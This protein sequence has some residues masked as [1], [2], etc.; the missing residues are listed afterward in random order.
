MPCKGKLSWEQREC[1]TN[2]NIKLLINSPLPPP[3]PPP[4]QIP[5][6]TTPFGLKSGRFNSHESICTVTSWKQSQNVR[7]E[8]I[9]PGPSSLHP[10]YPHP[11]LSR[12]ST[13]VQLPLP[14]AHRSP[15]PDGAFPRRADTP[16]SSLFLC[17][18][19]YPLFFGV[20]K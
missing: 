8:D 20:A 2:I 4:P 13:P 14:F 16:A 9:R 1:D 19:V 18:S 7:H 10:T 15:R 12:A 3:P 11:N 5:E 17:L 6:D